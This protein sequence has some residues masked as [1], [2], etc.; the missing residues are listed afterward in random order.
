[1]PAEKLSGQMSRSEIHRVAYLKWRDAP[2]GIPPGLA[3][4]FM[5][6][7]KAASTV[8]KLTGG[9]KMLGRPALV[10]Y[11]RFKKHCEHGDDAARVVRAIKDELE[12]RPRTDGSRTWL[13][14]GPDR[15]RL[16]KKVLERL[17]Q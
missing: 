17:D 5:T 8:R 12:G 9:G 3:I 11:D 10:S 16:A 4:D 1:M 7:L 6:R 2:P 15:L 14:E 13:G